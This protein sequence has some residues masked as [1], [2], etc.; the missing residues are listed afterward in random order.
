MQ[1]TAVRIGK[2]APT[3]WTRAFLTSRIR[4][5]TSDSN[6]TKNY[7][8][9]LYRHTQDPLWRLV[10]TLQSPVEGVYPYNALHDNR[11]TL[12]GFKQ[13]ESI[14]HQEDITAAA[15][16]LQLSGYQTKATPFAP[17]TSESDPPLPQRP[18]P[19]W[20][21]LCL[22][23]YRVKTP[24]HANG[25]LMDLVFSH[26]DLAAADIKGPL[27]T[28]AAYQLCRFNLLLPLRRVVNV[29]LDTP[30]PDEE[31]QFNAFLRA[32]SSIPF[33]SGESAKNVMSILKIM[34]ARQL[35]LWPSTYDALVNDQFATIVLAKHL[36][37]RMV[38]EDF[39]PTASHLE[40]FLRIFANNGRADLAEK[41]FAAIH[42]TTEGEIDHEAYFK[43]PRTRAN[44]LMLNSFER[45]R[46]ATAFLK[47]LSDSI[48]D[49]TPGY[50]TP[51][52]PVPRP[53]APLVHKAED[54]IYD[55]TA[56][57]HVAAKDLSTPTSRLIQIFLTLRV[58]PTIVTHTIL[59]RGLLLRNE[60]RKAEIFWSK[61]SKQSD[62]IID[63]EALTAGIQ[64][65]TRNEKPHE[66]FQ[67]LEKYSLKPGQ[68]L[69]ASQ[70]KDPPP[71][72]ITAISMNEFLVALNRI[73]RPD[74]VFRLWDYMDDLYGAQ[75]NA[76][77]LSILLQSAKLAHKMDDTLSGAIAK[78]K[79]LNPFKS[80]KVYTPRHSRVQGVDAVIS[81]IGHP[82]RGGLRRYTSSIWKDQEP[83]N[84]ARKIFLQV[85]FGNDPDGRLLS[86]ESPASATRESY[87]DDASS[88]IGLPDIAPK[89]YAFEPFPDLLTPD[90]KSHFPQIVITNANCF[91]YITLIGV[92][93]RANEIPLVLAWMKE[94]GIRPSD[95]TLAVSLVFWSEVSVQAP[96]VEQWSG[97]PGRNE[98]TKLVD[99]IRDWVGEKRIPNDQLLIK[100]RGVANRMRASPK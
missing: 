44:T 9:W 55:Q 74:A 19:S 46:E 4:R 87:D 82:S 5:N 67:L 91:N 72:E 88:S 66:A 61:L 27:L 32:L 8:E 57:F 50:P 84:F 35:K 20:V 69:T 34:D 22:V 12:E 56:A 98:Y 37:L 25:A 45:R 3:V 48:P 51:S 53:Q 71:V 96:L 94:L 33:R 58:K 1:A 21:I 15:S 23:G 64:A 93:G 6:A 41:F 85:L 77:T 78:F 29:F 70:I 86:V 62:M 99:W 39:T 92:G 17:T 30:L 7:I 38:K 42:R 24:A 31:R 80:V 75:P 90:G 43:D 52:L 14:L 76:L 79:L 68:D 49:S 63:K 89:K 73:Q 97:G 47:R 16:A 28:L 81:C 59:I 36:F 2:F 10:D 40:S 18:V 26:I 100:W 11:V 83:L 54:D 65:Y 95:S 13:W 60:F